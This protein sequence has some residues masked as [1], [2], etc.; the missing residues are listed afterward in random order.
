MLSIDTFNWNTPSSRSC[1]W[2]TQK[3]TTTPTSESNMAAR[4][5]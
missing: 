1:N 4:E 2:E 5:M 3:S